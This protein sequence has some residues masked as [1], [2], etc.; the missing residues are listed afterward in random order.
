MKNVLSVAGS[1]PSGGAGIQAD[2]KTFAARGTYGMAVLTS[3]TAQNTQGVSGVF[4]VPAEFVTQQLDMIFS[5][6][7]VDAV[8]IGMIVNAEIADAVARVLV[9]QRIKQPDLAIVLDPVMI[10]KG[11]AALLD[12]QAVD[13]LKFKLLPLASL[14]T[15]NLPEAGALLRIPVAETRDQ[16][17]LQGQAL[18]AKGCKAVLMKGGHMAGDN[19]PDLLLTGQ[20]VQWFEGLRIDTPNTH[21]TGCTLSSALAAELAKGQSLPDGV[22]EAKAYLARA[23]AKADTLNVGMKDQHGRSLGHGPVYHSV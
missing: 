4:P 23:I 19:C 21:G 14:L 2:L 9:Q 12:P 22:R 13:S 3:L 1:D 5:D 8:K 11:G 15:P 7:L 20:E 16:M 17:M 10:A 6:V 18:L